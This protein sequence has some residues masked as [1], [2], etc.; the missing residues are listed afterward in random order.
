MALSDTQNAIDRWLRAP[1][2]V[3]KA[4][5]DEN[6]AHSETH[7]VAASDRLRMLL[8]GD[9]AL[10]AVGRLEIYANAYFHRIFSVLQNDYPALEAALGKERFYDLVTSYLLIEPSTNPSL[11]FA[12]AKLPGF[13]EDHEAAAP[14]RRAAPWA[15]ELAHLE[16]MRS[17]V[18]DVADGPILDQD[19]VSQL[20]PE[21]FGSLDLRLA[22]WVRSANYSHPVPD[23]WRAGVHGESLQEIDLSP[24][25]SAVLIWRKDEQS[26][27][28]TLTPLEAQA[29]DQAGAGIRFDALCVWAAERVN[30]EEAPALAAGWLRQ[31]IGDAILLG[32]S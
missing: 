26:V 21:D 30:E 29:L 11:R 20:A 2:G 24:S 19:A 31:W 23:L 4:L 9:N 16:W 13:I 14:I 3:A 10:D 28:R 17:E 7:P 25:P 6:A 32:D 5:R 12:G 1:E 22:P 15:F 8:C 18:F 27:H